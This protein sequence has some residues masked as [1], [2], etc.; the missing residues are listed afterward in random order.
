MA[1]AALHSGYQN[2]DWTQIMIRTI[3]FVSFFAAS[4]ALADDDRVIDGQEAEIRIQIE[5]EHEYATNA[6]EARL[7]VEYYQKGDSVHVETVLNNDQCAASSGSYT[8]QVRYRG[9]DGE[10]QTAEF[11][12][13]WERS[14]AEPVTLAKDYYVAE[15]IDVRRVRSRHLR[16]EC[17]PAPEEGAGD[18][19]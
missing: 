11:E 8:L 5:A 13:I 3:V 2:P 7:E 14:D 15:N 12:E 1:A 19:P 9:D 17:A 18:E 10:T 6:C 4:A 16:C